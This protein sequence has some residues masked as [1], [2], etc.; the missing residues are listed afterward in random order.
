MTATE[1]PTTTRPRASR[2]R[3]GPLRRRRP[4]GDDHARRAG[5]DEHDLRADARRDLAATC[6]RPTATRTCAASCS[7]APAGR[8]A[9]GST[10]PPRRR[11]KSRRRSATSA[12]R[13]P[14][15][16]SSTCATPRRSCCTTSTRRRSAR[17]T[18]APPATASTWRWAATSAS[19]PRRPSSTRASP[20][21]ASCPRAAARGCCR[22]WSATPRR[23]RSRSA[24]TRLTAAEALELGIVNHAVPDDEFVA[25]TAAGRRRDRRQRAARRAGDQA[26]DARRRDRDVRAERA[27]RV[28]AA[29]AAARTRTTSGKGSPRS[30]R[31]GRPTS[32]GRDDA[33]QVTLLEAMATTRAIRRY[34]PDPIPDADLAE[35]LWY[36]QRAP[37]GTN[38]QKF[39]FITLRRDDPV[40]APARA[41]LTESFRA[42]AGSAK[43]ADL[44]RDG[45][46]EEGSPRARMQAAMQHYVDHFDTVPVV[47]LVGL[48]RYR[49]P[50]PAEGA[51]VY[52]ACQNLLLAAR[53]LGYGGVMTGWHAFVEDEL[54]DADRAPRRR[55]A[56]RRRS[57]SACRPGRHG[58]LRRKPLPALVHDGVWGR[59]ADWLGEHGRGRGRWLTTRTR[60]S[61]WRP[62]PPSTSCGRPAVAGRWTCT[63]TGPASGGATAAM[64]RLNE[65]FDAI[66]A[67]VPRRAAGRSEPAVPTGR[68]PPPCRAP[69]CRARG[70]SAGPRRRVVHDRGA[71]GRGV[72]GAAGRRLVA[73]R[74][75]RRRPAVPPRRR[76]SASRSCPGAASTSC[77]MPAPAPSP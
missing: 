55:R 70:G 31:S 67:D 56:L 54:R 64:Q 15:P 14:A 13:R 17:S 76:C 7:P 65:A 58:P 59:Q 74:A 52:P 2:A 63:R 21:G 48:E 75:A 60:C 4:R 5:A 57:R 47:V 3:R 40:A 20:S 77:P 43:R 36:A 24:A 34:T 9:P 35:I 42:R 46:P 22:A 53:A 27:P 69:P 51:S 23:P 30:W 28:P 45:A 71:A 49:P 26:D 68:R 39:R 33:R 16:A 41:L 18:A 62:T 25:F 1:A 32:P 38:R 72:R 12:R 61:A 19:P 6:W 11:T 37:S 10:S 66:L 8:S 44:D 50:N 73:R 29:A